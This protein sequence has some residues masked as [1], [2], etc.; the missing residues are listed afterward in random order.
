M[1]QKLSLLERFFFRSSVSRSVFICALSSVTP[2]HVVS[3]MS[4]AASGSNWKAAKTIDLGLGDERL[5]FFQR[6]FHLPLFQRR[7]LRPEGDDDPLRFCPLSVSAS[8][9]SQR[10]PGSGSTRVNSIFWPPL[11]RMPVR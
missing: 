6:K 9:C 3:S 5:R 10:V 2:G 1:S 4:L 11:P 7:K 8:A